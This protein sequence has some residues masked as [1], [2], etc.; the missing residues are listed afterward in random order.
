MQSK[1][2]GS[3]SLW[4][5]TN[6]R[7]PT[8]FFYSIWMNA[9]N[10]CASGL[11]TLH[12][13][14]AQ[15]QKHP[16]NSLAWAEW[17]P[18]F[19]SKYTRLS[20]TLTDMVKCSNHTHLQWPHLMSSW[21]L[22]SLSVYFSDTWFP[23]KYCSGLSS[24]AHGWVMWGRGPS[25]LP[26]ALINLMNYPPFSSINPHLRSFSY[27]WTSDQLRSSPALTAHQHFPPHI[28]L[29]CHFFPSGF[30]C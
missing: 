12:I 16:S 23:V 6:T 29:S 2:P 9:V 22:F 26:L 14:Q 1:T 17:G 5:D 19:A 20:N 13:F 7:R 15:R 25:P 30:G 10:L 21:W 27:S 11:L 18:A 4:R 3:S 28:S 8:L 24:H